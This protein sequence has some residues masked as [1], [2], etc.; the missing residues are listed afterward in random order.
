MKRTNPLLRQLCVGPGITAHMG[1]ASEYTVDFS[2]L[3]LCEKFEMICSKLAIPPEDITRFGL[4]V[5]LS[6]KV[7]KVAPVLSALALVDI[8]RLQRRTAIDVIKVC[9]IHP[10]F[11][12]SETVISEILPTGALVTWAI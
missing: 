10:V 7:I 5:W 2:T 12:D 4:K 3:T 6:S 11:R 1:H 9:R 8:D